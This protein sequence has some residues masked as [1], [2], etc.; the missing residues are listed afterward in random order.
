MVDL[1]YGGDTPNAAGLLKLAIHLIER[2]LPL[3]R[4]PV[5]EI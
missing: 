1:V 3:Q 5:G 4:T 2:E